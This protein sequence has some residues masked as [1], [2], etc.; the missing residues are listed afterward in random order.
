MR[1][2][3]VGFGRIV[4]AVIAVLIALAVLGSAFKL[5]LV[6]GAAF[7]IWKLFFAEPAPVERAPV[8]LPAPLD[9]SLPPEVDALDADAMERDAERARLDRELAQAIEVANA[10][11][12]AVAS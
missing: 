12:K 8:R 6:A 9:L 7:V 4:L 5:A 2:R 10:R 11:Q 3:K 1:Q